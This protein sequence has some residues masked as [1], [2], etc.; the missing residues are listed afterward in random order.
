MRFELKPKGIEMQMWKKEKFTPFMGK[1]NEALLVH[2]QF[3]VIRK[4]RVLLK[5]LYGELLKGE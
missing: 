2:L 5:Q 1:I 4:Q 3:T